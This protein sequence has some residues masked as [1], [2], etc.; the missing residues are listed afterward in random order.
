MSYMVS[1]YQL[2]HSDGRSISIAFKL[3]KN[4]HMCKDIQ[5]DMIFK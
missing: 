4:I 1:F 5:N 2:S 3:V